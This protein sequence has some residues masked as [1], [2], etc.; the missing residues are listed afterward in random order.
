MSFVTMVEMQSAESQ[1]NPPESEFWTLPVDF[2]RCTLLSP[3]PYIACNAPLV[4][5]SHRGHHVC[6]VG[7]NNTEPRADRIDADLSLALGKED[8]VQKPPC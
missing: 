6:P 2:W 3:L 1:P 8:R 5:Y 7:G 4:M